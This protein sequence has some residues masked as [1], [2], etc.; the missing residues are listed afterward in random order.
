MIEGQVR[1]ALEGKLYKTTNNGSQGGGHDRGGRF[2]LKKP[3]PIRGHDKIRTK[4][5][6]KQ[7]LYE[8]R[9]KRL[10]RQLTKRKN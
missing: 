7:D 4:E 6:E 2:S 3:Y 5:S 10:G 9:L 1:D 8:G